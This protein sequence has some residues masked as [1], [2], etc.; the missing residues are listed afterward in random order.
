MR[1]VVDSSPMTCALAVQIRDYPCNFITNSPRL[2][3]Q[4]SPEAIPH[5]ILSPGGWLD[6]NS[7][8]LYPTVEGELMLRNMCPELVILAPPA[9][10]SGQILYHHTAAAA[11]AKLGLSC[12]KTSIVIAPSH[13]YTTEAAVAVSVCPDLLVTED[14]YPRDTQ[15]GRIETVP[16]LDPRRLTGNDDFDY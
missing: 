8:L 5:K 16:S 3:R 7:N 4:L 11:W 12:A 10:R 2:I 9:L 14:D 6:K 13:T 15:A 1:I